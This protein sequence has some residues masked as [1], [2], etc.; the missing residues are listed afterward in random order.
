MTRYQPIFR[1]YEDEGGDLAAFD[2]IEDLL[3][4]IENKMLTK[5]TK[6]D[7][8]PKELQRIRDLVSSPN[9][10]EEIDIQKSVV[11][12]LKKKVEIRETQ[13]GLDSIEKELD[14]S[15]NIDL[16]SSSKKEVEKPIKSKRNLL[17]ERAFELLKKDDVLF[18]PTTGKATFAI[19]NIRRIQVYGPGFS[20]EAARKIQEQSK[21]EE[22]LSL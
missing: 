19:T 17:D 7:K 21:R 16:T 15:K 10:K 4:D 12:K 5:G 22:V 8:T 13:S 3:R 6:R 2:T 11:N 1:W 14:I 20:I 18:D 9:F